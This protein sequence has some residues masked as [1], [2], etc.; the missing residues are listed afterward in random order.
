MRAGGADVDPTLLEAP[1]TQTR[2]DLKR[3]AYEGD[4]D[5]SARDCRDRRREPP[6]GRLVGLAASYAVR[7]CQELGYEAAAR[8]VVSG[9]RGC[10]RLSATRDLTLWT[11]RPPPTPRPRPG[12][13][14][15]VEA[16][17]PAPEEDLGCGSSGRGGAGGGE[18]PDAYDRRS[19]RPIGP[20]AGGHRDYGH[21]AAQESSGR[22]RFRRRVQLA[23]I[24]LGAG[25]AELAAPILQDLSGEIE[26]RNLEAWEQADM[27]LPPLALLLRCLAKLDA[28]A[29]ERQ[30]LY[31]RICRLDPLQALSIK[32]VGL[33]TL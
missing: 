25:R 15:Q 29:E 22:G 26:R 6:A 2:Q 17:A 13:K 20:R 23:Q 33:G 11:T 27:L 28:S 5:A 1:P 8:A 30:K 16:A 14:E 7:A 31:A 32:K 9:L 3:L 19:R 21:E 10:W 24:C 18:A 12:L 4:L